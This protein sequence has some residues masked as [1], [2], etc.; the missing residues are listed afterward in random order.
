MVAVNMTV[1][2]NLSLVLKF[3]TSRRSSSA[4]SVSG[5]R[6]LTGMWSRIFCTS[7]SKPMSII[8]SASSSTTYVH[9]LSTRYRFSSTSIRRPGVAITISQPSRSL[10]P[11]S[12]LDIPPMI[13]TVRISS[14]LANLSV[15]SSICWA[16]SRVGA[17]MIAYGPWSISSCRTILGSEVIQTRSGI[18]NAAVLP[19]KESKGIG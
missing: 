1:W 10:K 8:R 14:F 16:S 19:L 2:R 6:L 7:A 9:R 13:A 5:F 3:S 12:S 17:R 15:S 11:C 4:S 18:R